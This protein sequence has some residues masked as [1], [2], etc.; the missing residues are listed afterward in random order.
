MVNNSNKK[1]IDLKTIYSGSQ[2]N[3]TKLILGDKIIV[4]TYSFKGR[5]DTLTIQL[6]GWENTEDVC[7][8]INEYSYLHGI[9]ATVALDDIIENFKQTTYFFKNGET[10][11]Q[12]DKSIRYTLLQNAYNIVK[13]SDRGF[14]I[15][16][17]LKAYYEDGSYDFITDLNEICKE[18]SLLGI[19]TLGIVGTYGSSYKT[20]QGKAS[21]F[22]KERDFKYLM[23]VYSRPRIATGSYSFISFSKELGYN[24]YISDTP[25]AIYAGIVSI[26]PR[27]ISTTNSRTM[28]TEETLPVTSDQ[29]QTLATLG[30]TTFD[31]VPGRGVVVKDGVTL[32]KDNGYHDLTNT[33]IALYINEEIKNLCDSYVGEIITK[34]KTKEE[35]INNF[36][37]SL[38]MKGII[39]SYTVRITYP[40]QDSV[41]ILTDFVP[42]GTIRSLSVETTAIIRK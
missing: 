1:V 33:R 28:I 27:N 31:N 4:I 2:Y 23:V 18:R 39:K 16:V 37:T 12:I 17:A 3:N 11:D 10:Q 29:K 38:V 41:S 30:I 22:S 32:Q 15:V 34:F 19:P 21:Q 26:I 9:S 25:E 13:S 6:E 20:I 36:M 5:S 42:L 8:R 40:S 24:S 14:N 35:E 7:Q